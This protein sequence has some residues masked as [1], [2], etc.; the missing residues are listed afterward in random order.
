MCCYKGTNV[1]DKKQIESGSEMDAARIE[2]TRQGV[3]R[4]KGKRLLIKKLGQVAL[5]DRWDGRLRVSGNCLY[6]GQ[7]EGVFADS[8][9]GGELSINPTNRIV[10]IELGR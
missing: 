2:A 10:K 8:E 5:G 3:I 7:D 9:L 4:L 1:Q 6:I